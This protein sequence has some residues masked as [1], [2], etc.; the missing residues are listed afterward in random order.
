MASEVNQVTI[1]RWDHT[2]RP[3]KLRKFAHPEGWWVETVIRYKSV[4]PGQVYYE[5]LPEHALGEM[6]VVYEAFFDC[7]GQRWRRENHIQFTVDIT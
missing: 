2:L 6:H 3:S 4:Y 1:I 5:Q 7:E